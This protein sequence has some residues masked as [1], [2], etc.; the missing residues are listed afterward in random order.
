MLTPGDSHATGLTTINGSYT[1]QAG[2]TLAIELGGTTVGSQYDRLSVTG[3][4]TIA[5]TLSVSLID[6]FMPAFGDDFQILLATTGLT[7][8]FGTHNLPSLSESALEWLIDYS[9]I[10]LTLS[11]GLKGDFNGDGVVNAADYV[12]WRD[13]SGSAA[14]YDEWVDNFGNAANG[15]GSFASSAAV[16]EPTTGVLMAMGLILLSTS[17]GRRIRRTWCGE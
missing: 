2:A 12:H 11:V 16:P 3:P 1:Q 14:Q 5:G 4:A 15:S 9:T 17:S 6:G 13:R 7:G 8:T 10:A